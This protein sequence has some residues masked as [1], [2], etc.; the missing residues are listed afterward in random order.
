MATTSNRERE[1]LELIWAEPDNDDARLVYGDWLLQHGDPRGE[2]I[3]LQMKRETHPLSPSEAA[4]EQTLWRAHGNVWLGPLAHAVVPGSAVFRRGFLARCKVGF[5]SPGQRE[6]LLQDPMWATVEHVECDDPAVLAAP[7]L[8]A[9][10]AAGPISLQTLQALAR[11]PGRE[12]IRHLYY[13]WHGHPYEKEQ[14]VDAYRFF[15]VDALDLDHP[16]VYLPRLAFGDFDIDRQIPL[17]GDAHIARI[18]WLAIRRRLFMSLEEWLS[19]RLPRPGL[20]MWLDAHEL[21][22]LPDRT[23]VLQPYHGWIFILHWTPAGVELGVEWR[24]ACANSD[25]R[26]LQLAVAPVAEDAFARVT[27]TVVGLRRPR[28]DRAL[29][30]ALE[31]FGDVELY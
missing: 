2:F 29:R 18:P 25:L 24:T 6:A 27:A 31:K 14:F 9:M 5:E 26:A 28:H 16:S 3:M 22:R 17:L 19:F 8:R 1:L 30:Q 21:A 4:H 23:I 10:Y 20:M 15:E 12:R 7:G 11:T 13:R